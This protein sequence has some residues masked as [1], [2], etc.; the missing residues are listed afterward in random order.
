MAASEPILPA[1]IRRIRLP[2][3]GP[4]VR[5]AN[6][7]AA[8]GIAAG[9]VPTPVSWRTR[10]P[11]WSASSNARREHRSG[12]VGL[13]GE[14]VGLAHL[15]EDLRFSGKQRIEPRGDAEEMERR[16]DPAQLHEEVGVAEHRAGTGRGHVRIVACDVELGAVAGRE[17]DRLESLLREPCGDLERRIGS[18]VQPLAKVERRGAVG[19]SHEHG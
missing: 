5:S 8:A 2:A 16:V 4:T 1:P 18:Q 6:A 11:A 19:R 14:L 9:S 12:R 10:L 13:H 3:S 7:A 17:R 15:A